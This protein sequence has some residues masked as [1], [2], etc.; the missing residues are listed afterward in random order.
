MSL[1][2]I[3]PIVLT[4][5][6]LKNGLFLSMASY[7]KFRAYFSKGIDSQNGQVRVRLGVA[8]HVKIN[9]LFQLQTLCGNVLQN[10]HEQHRNVL[11]SR[12][13]VDDSTDGLQFLIQLHRVQ[14]VLQ[15]THFS[16]L[17]GHDLF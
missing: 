10:I 5:S 12:H 6:P 11:A 3:H 7:I 15:L 4:E 13:R 8:H 14:L 2:L 1:I 9:Q 17:L 16:S